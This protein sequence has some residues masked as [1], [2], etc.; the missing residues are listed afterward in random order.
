[1]AQ[2]VVKLAKR[3]IDLIEL[4][5]LVKPVVIIY[6]N[7][8]EYHVVAGQVG[9]VKLLIRGNIRRADYMQQLTPMY[10]CMCV[11]VCV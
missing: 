7:W 9:Q 1:M 11:C 4:V 10:I 5:Q 6:L 3:I 8:N 2:L